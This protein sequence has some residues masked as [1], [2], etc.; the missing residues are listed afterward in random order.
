MTISTYQVDGIIKAYNK[1]NRLKV[2]SSIPQ[3]N[4]EDKYTDVVTLS[5]GEDKNDAAYKAISYNLLGIILNSK[6]R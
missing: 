2:K 1:Q 3:E 6:E 5:I 4:R